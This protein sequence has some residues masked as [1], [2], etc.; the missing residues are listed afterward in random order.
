MTLTELLFEADGIRVSLVWKK[1][2]GWWYHTSTDGQAEHRHG[3]FWC[4]SE[5]QRNAR[6]WIKRNATTKKEV[7]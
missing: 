4:K 7:A 6:R 5:C 3:P 2:S 1:Q